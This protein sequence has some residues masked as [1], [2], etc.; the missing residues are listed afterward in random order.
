MVAVLELDA[1][2]AYLTIFLLF[3]RGLFVPPG[4][5]KIERY[6]RC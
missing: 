5:F 2:L 3:V 4:A 1:I 6:N